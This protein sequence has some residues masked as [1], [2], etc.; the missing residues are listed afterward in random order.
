MVVLTGRRK[1]PLEET[2]ATI[3]KAGGKAV[4]KTGDLTKAAAETRIAKAID[5]KFGRCDILVN[6]A[7]PNILLRQ[8]RHLTPGGAA[9]AVRGNP[10]RAVSCCE[11]AVPHRHQT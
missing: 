2:A 4:V 1:E 5:K 8:R 7:G 6:N 3:K 10:V 11:A 9:P